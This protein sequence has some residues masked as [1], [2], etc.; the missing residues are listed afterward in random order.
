[1]N[2]QSEN[3]AWWER[4]DRPS[5]NLVMFGLGY[6]V[7]SGGAKGASAVIAWSF[8]TAGIVLGLVSSIPRTVRWWRNI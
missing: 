8:F 4:L 6:I 5:D 1:M 7:L 2:A 3:S